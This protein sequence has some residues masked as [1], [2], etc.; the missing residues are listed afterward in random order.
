MTNEER[1]ALIARARATQCYETCDDADHRMADALLSTLDEARGER[2]RLARTV[3]SME[4]RLDAIGDDEP[5][6]ASW[7]AEWQRAQIAERERDEARGQLAALHAAVVAHK[8]ACDAL[9]GASSLHDDFWRLTDAARHARNALCAALSD[10][11]AAAKAHEARV[12]EPVERERDTLLRALYFAGP[13][14]PLGTIAAACEFI[15]TLHRHAAERDTLAAALAEHRRTVAEVLAEPHAYIGARERAVL[16]ALAAPPADLAAQR[17]ARVRAEALREA[18]QR[19]IDTGA[20]DGA[21]FLLGYA[22]G[23]EIEAEKG[24]ARG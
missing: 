13:A 6:R 7:L 1:E 17:D 14:D 23:I 4:A 2:E 11:A 22:R 10:T 5:K 21:S 18:R 3:D 8:D 12:R 9:S 15:D 16:D 24:G 19:M 20:E